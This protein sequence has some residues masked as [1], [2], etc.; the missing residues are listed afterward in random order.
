MTVKTQTLRVRTT[1][2]HVRPWEPTDKPLCRHYGRSALLCGEPVA[3]VTAEVT[4]AGRGSHTRSMS[5]CEQHYASLIESKPA[6]HAIKKSAM[7]DARDRLIAAHRDE[8]NG[9]VAEA[10]KRL[11]GGA[12]L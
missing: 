8:F 5:L 2:Y 7:D 9:Y 11:T 3:V 6:P 4:P 10:L 12:S 1:T